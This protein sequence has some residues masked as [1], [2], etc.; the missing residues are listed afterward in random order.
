MEKFIG[1]ILAD[2]SLKET[3]ASN[4]INDKLCQSACKH[5]IRA[6]DTVSKDEIVYLIEEMKKNVPLCPHG[7]PIIV[8]ISQKELEKMFKRVL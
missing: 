8:K 6:G 1:D 5:S 3:T 7:R 4:I 2:E